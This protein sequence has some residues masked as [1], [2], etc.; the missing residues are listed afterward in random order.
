MF[1]M[2]DE[3]KIRPEDTSAGVC[4]RGD[5][6]SPIKPLCPLSFMLFTVI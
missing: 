3:S 5:M 2:A 4:R 1:V 6:S